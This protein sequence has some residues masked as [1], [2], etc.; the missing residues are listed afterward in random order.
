MCVCLCVRQEF[1]QHA[2]NQRSVESTCRC[3]T[4]RPYRVHPTFQSA[5]R[6]Q[7][8]R[9]FEVMCKKKKLCS[10]ICTA[11]SKFIVFAF[12]S[13]FVSF[14]SPSLSHA[15]HKIHLP[16]LFG[17]RVS[18]PKNN[19]PQSSFDSPRVTFLNCQQDPP[20]VSL[21]G[22]EVQGHEQ[23]LITA[24]MDFCCTNSNIPSRTFRA[25]LRF[26]RSLLQ[27][28]PRT[29]F[30]EFPAG[31]STCPGGMASHSE[32]VI[33]HHRH[34]HHSNHHLHRHL[35]SPCSSLGK[36]D[37]RHPLVHTAALLAEHAQ[38]LQSGAFPRVLL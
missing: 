31:S 6:V 25:N 18:T 34:L 29:D 38:F 16:F 36:R 20:L 17:N 22:E 2:A 14:S 27:D 5:P 28:N 26:T 15:L 33:C 23:S 32:R 4:A 10:S 3:R 19:H 8:N 7:E 1:E 30:R 37:G 21:F 11:A 24:P 9:S 12:Q 13:H 35:C